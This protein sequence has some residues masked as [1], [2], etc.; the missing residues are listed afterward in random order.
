[1]RNIF[2]FIR[3]YFNLLLFLFLQV[4]SLYFISSYSKYH[5]AAFGNVTNRVTGRFNARYHEITKY[6]ALNSTNEQ[7]AKANEALLNRMPSNFDEVR[8]NAITYTDSAKTDSVK[9]IRRFLFRSATVIS[10]S[11]SA[12]NNFLVLAAGSRNQLHP[13]MGVIDPMKGVVGIITEVTGDY[14]VVM[15]LLHRDSRISGKLKRGGET[16]TLTWD[17]TEPNVIMLNNIPKSAKVYKGDTVITSGFSTAFPKGM[18]VGRVTAVYK[19]KS[20]SNFRIKLKTTADFNSLEYVYAIDNKF[21]EP[22]EALLK[23]AEKQL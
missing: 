7:L 5:E 4:L 16:G 10:N 17:G 21:Q 1:M 13:G 6:F 11:V 9:K 3:R 22:V 19:E 20:T 2:L 23:K 15:S 14:S 8:E 12:Q 18:M